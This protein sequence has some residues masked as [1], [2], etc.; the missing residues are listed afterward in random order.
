MKKLISMILALTIAVGA[1]GCEN[2]EERQTKILETTKNKRVLVLFRWNDGADN[3]M[4]NAADTAFKGTELKYKVNVT[5][6][7]KI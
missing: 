5:F 1:T 6:T 2:E 7:Q 4:D 3:T